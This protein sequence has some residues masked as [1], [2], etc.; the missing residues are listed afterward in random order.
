LLDSTKFAPRCFSGFSRLHS[1]ALV[2]FRE[3]L[4]VRLNFRVQ[5]GVAVAAKNCDES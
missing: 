3:Q 1:P 5:V 2:G 4:Q